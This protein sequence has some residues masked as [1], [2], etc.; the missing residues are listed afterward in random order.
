MDVATR[1]GD[2]VR[3]LPLLDALNPRYNIRDHQLIVEGVTEDL[4]FDRVPRVDRCTVCHLGIDKKGFEDQPNPFK[5]HPNVDLFLGLSSP[6]P[7]KEFGCTSC[8]SGRGRGT[9][10]TSA[11][12]TPS[13]PEQAA[14]WKEKYG[15]KALHHW[16]TPMRPAPYTEAGCFECHSGASQTKSA[17]TLNLGLAVIERA[18][19]YGCHQIEKYEDRSR[20]G[21]SLRHVADKVSPEWA[22]HWLNDPKAFREHTWMPSFF[23]QSNNADMK[24]RTDQE[25][26]AMIQYLIKES[27]DFKKPHSTMP[28]GNPER[29]LELANSLGCQGCHMLEGESYPDKLTLNSLRRQQGPNLTGLGTKTTALWVYNWLKDPKSYHPETRMPNLRL[30]DQEAADTA[31]YLV[32]S[33]KADFA[34]TPI[35]AADADVLDAIALEFMVPGMTRTRARKKLAT[36]PLDE[37]QQYAGSKLIRRYGCFACHDIPGFEDARPIGTELTEIASKSV[38]KLDFGL[39]HDLPHVNYAW[40]EEKLRNPRAFDEGMVKSPKDK[41]RMPNFDLEPEAVTAV[42]TA[43]LG[44]TKP[45]EELTKMVPR[46]PKNLFVEKGE[47]LIGELNCRGCHE[48]KGDGGAIHGSVAYWLEHIRPSADVEE[49]AEEEEEDDWG[50]EEESDVDL[51]AIARAY[52]PPNLTGEG[53]K[54]Q[55]AWLFNFLQTPETIR[56]WLS[57]RMPSYGLN[58]EQLNTLT[59]FFSYDADKS[60]PFASSPTVDTNSATYAA[61]RDMFSPQSM[62]C[63]RCHITGGKTPIGSTEDNWAPDLAKAHDRLRA[64]WILQW[65]EDPQSL[66]PG[67]KMPMYWAEGEASPVTH[68]D[69]DPQRQREAIRE[70]IQSLGK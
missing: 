56:P 9:S 31:A 41:L 58:D 52:N 10:F 5:T 49:D 46:T 54:V 60:Y 61:G 16:D 25:A 62:S 13:S 30:S 48:L 36:M 33:H 65:L 6:H 21:P 69:G 27:S 35:P 42:V 68:L 53:A 19:C 7:L 18:G 17:E 66:E 26:G 15:W 50:E 38:S 2:T 55:P 23:N 57:L 3:D 4:I 20:V 22:Y 67:T 51:E 29:G 59:A 8:H 11:A 32:S 63:A 47:A 43:L 34:K 24:E 37:K 44:F 12:H 14:E 45:D 39:R 70:Y 28:T 40:F 1:I 64:D